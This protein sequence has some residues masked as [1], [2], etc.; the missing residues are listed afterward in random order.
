MVHIQYAIQLYDSV[1]G[2]FSGLHIYYIFLTFAAITERQTQR[3]VLLR[4][5]YTV[6]ALV[7]FLSH[8]F[9][10]C[11]GL[12][13]FFRL[14]LCKMVLFKIRPHIDHLTVLLISTRIPSSLYWP[15]TTIGGTASS[16]INTRAL[17]N[18]RQGYKFKKAAGK[19]K[20]ELAAYY[21]MVKMFSA[22]E[23]KKLLPG[24]K[25]PPKEPWGDKFLVLVLMPWGSLWNG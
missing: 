7:C 10:F 6:N 14:L 9:L 20:H 2:F 15:F 21:S 16:S 22:K 25:S 13:L 8:F 19:S 1:M 23:K 5:E 12:F 17:V 11:F 24:T 4:A 18:K 3:Q